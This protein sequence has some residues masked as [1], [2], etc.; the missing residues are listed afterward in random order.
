MTSFP[1]ELREHPRPMDTRPEP[2]LPGESKQIGWYVVEARQ[3]EGG[4]VRYFLRNIPR[5][6]GL[7]GRGLLAGGRR[8]PEFCHVRGWYPLPGLEVGAPLPRADVEPKRHRPRYRP[9]DLVTLDE[10][11]LLPGLEVVSI[12]E[13]HVPDGLEVERFEVELDEDGDPIL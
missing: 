13:A 5:E 12:G 1:L 9:G 2:P 4:P 7:D 3:A 10:L 11:A 8:W 6:G